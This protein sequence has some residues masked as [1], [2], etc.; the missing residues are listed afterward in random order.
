MRQST[1]MLL[2]EEQTLIRDAARA[3]AQ[4][5]VA[6]HA[7]AWELAGEIPRPLLAE[8]GPL[9]FM[10]MCVPPEWGAGADMVSYVIALEEIAAA[11][12]GLSTVM[13]VNNSPD[14]AALLAYGSSEQKER[15]LKPLARGEIVAIKAIA[16]NAAI[17]G[18]ILAD[19]D[20]CF[21][22][23]MAL[24]LGSARELATAHD[25]RCWPLCRSDRLACGLPS[26]SRSLSFEQS[27]FLPLV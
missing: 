26:S 23:M 8:M 9:G 4:E 18:S 22:M 2:N 25:T 1:A 16:L 24:P 21:V 14:C 11:D 27:Q 3:F 17:S 10:G 19:P 6:P 15:W 20:A 13:S 7:R 12:G 5:Q